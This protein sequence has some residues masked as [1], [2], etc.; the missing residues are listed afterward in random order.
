MK[1]MLMALASTA[2]LALLAPAGAAAH[3]HRHH[4][5]SHKHAS[6]A[7]ILRFGAVSALSSPTT[8]TPTPTPPTPESAGTVVS[9][10]KEV[11]TIMLSD[12]TTVS[13]KVTQETRIH[14]QSATP[15]TETGDDDEQGDSGQAPE[16]SDQ[17]T[18]NDGQFQGQHGD[19][20]AHAACDASS[21]G[22]ESCPPSVLVPGAV[23]LAAELKLTPKGAVWDEVAVIH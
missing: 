22:Q 12:K 16:S 6:S 5:R 2:A 21:P 8:T 1:R 13:G 9:F 18:S 15:P 3:H 19:A 23:V 10:E 20:M 11:L 7:R 14:C 17:G 4:G